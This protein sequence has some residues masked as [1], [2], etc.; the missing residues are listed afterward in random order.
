[1]QLQLHLMSQEEGHFNAQHPTTKLAHPDK[2]IHDF[3]RSPPN[4]AP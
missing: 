4:M 2:D 3:V 1:M